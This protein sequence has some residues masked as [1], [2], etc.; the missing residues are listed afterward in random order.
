MATAAAVLGFV[1]CLWPLIAALAGLGALAAGEP[2]GL[3]AL[4]L[5]GLV[6]TGLVV[7]GVSL[8]H[9]GSRVWALRAAAALHLLVVLVGFVG[10][11]G[12]GGE[13]G[14]TGAVTMLVVTAPLPVLTLVFS[15]RPVVRSW[16]AAAGPW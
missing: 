10:L 11:L 6:G 16:L 15:L 2:G 9:R 13:D 5:G 4:L 8:L 7:G 1:A 12:W 3:V 14:G